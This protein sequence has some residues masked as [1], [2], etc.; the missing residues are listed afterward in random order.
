MCNNKDSFYEIQNYHK[1]SLFSFQLCLL[2][3]V[4]FSQHQDFRCYAVLPGCPLPESLYTQNNC[5]KYNS[6]SMTNTLPGCT[7]AWV[8]LIDYP[9]RL[10]VGWSWCGKVDAE[11][12][13][14]SAAAERWSQVD[15]PWTSMTAVPGCDEAASAD[16]NSRRPDHLRWTVTVWLSG[17]GAKRNQLAAQNYNKENFNRTNEPEA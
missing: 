8:T 6:L 17:V 3:L 2:L 7:T 12:G 14:A 1:T 10:V 15:R 11:D 16:R 4:A 9:T 5:L 13:E